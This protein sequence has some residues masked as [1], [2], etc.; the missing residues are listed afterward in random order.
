MKH[1]YDKLD[2]FH[3]LDIQNDT[4]PSMFVQE[5]AY[6]ILI[7]TFPIKEAAKELY[8]E[9]QAFVFDDKTYY[10]YDRVERHFR[11]MKTMENVYELLN[12]KTNATMKMV[13]AIHESIDAMEEQ[14]YE[15]SSL[16]TFMRYWLGYKKDLSRLHRIL[17]LGI[18]TVEGFID[19]YIKE[20]DFLAIHFKDIH[21]HLSRTNRSVLLAIDKLSNL[22]TFYTSR[23][24][25]RMNKMIYLL[26]IFSTIFL[27]LNLIVGYFGMNTQN[28]P[29]SAWA[30]GSMIVTTLIAICAT[31]MGGVLFYVRKKL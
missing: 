23:N 10:Y 22:Y 28:L 17:T 18:E 24:N 16:E 9:A 4:H 5:T 3:I 8:G 15:N 25:E 13:A 12:D 6:D 30:S 11:E 27:P 20:E 2:A 26:T 21:E 31:L 14:L 19:S 1:L 29:F 7:L